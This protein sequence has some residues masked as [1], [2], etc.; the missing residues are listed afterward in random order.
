[1][2]FLG[3][4]LAFGVENLRESLNER[5]VARQY[6]AGF[7]QDFARDYEWLESEIQFRERQMAAALTALEFYKGRELDVDVFFEAFWTVLPSR[8]LRSKPQ[9]DGRSPQLG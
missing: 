6:F 9:Y 1:M 4:A 5:T 3:V 8:P 7:A 2:V